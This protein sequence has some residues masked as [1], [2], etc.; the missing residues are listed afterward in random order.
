M[1]FTCAIVLNARIS[2]LGFFKLYYLGTGRW[3]ISTA[4]L[5]LSV[6]KNLE[7]KIIVAFVI[8]YRGSFTVDGEG[9]D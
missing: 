3:F 9:E 2:F 6:L 5:R 4:G 1:L 7:S 8:T